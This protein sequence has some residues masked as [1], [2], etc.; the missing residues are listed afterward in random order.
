MTRTIAALIAIIA[1]ANPSLPIATQAKLA[2]TLARVS[3]AA[4]FAPTEIAKLISSESRWHPEAVSPDGL[5]V[6][7]GQIRTKV[8]HISRRTLLNPYLNIK[9]TVKIAN[10][11]RRK[12]GV[13]WI[14]GY[15][16]LGC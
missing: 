14:R 6:G 9:Y 7:L 5:D 11:W 12:C 16:G 13:N 1:T 10:R 3:H 15:K 8:Q 4:H 2:R